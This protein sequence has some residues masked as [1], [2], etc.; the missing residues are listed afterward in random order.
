MLVVGER[1]R[2]QSSPVRSDRARGT[3]AAAA[4]VVVVV[5]MI[6]VVIMVVLMLMLVTPIVVMIVSA[7][8]FVARVLPLVMVP[9]LMEVSMRG[10]HVTVPTIRHEVD[11]SAAC[12]VFAAMFR[13]MSL[14]SSGYMQIERLWRWP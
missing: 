9:F 12:V 14:M 1:W 10:V 4:S 11:R 7:V 2:V 6:A 5:P 8:F 3:K 13:P